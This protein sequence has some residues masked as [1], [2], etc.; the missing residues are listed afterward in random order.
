M[1]FNAYFSSLFIRN[2]A[3]LSVFLAKCFELF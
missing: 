2:K 1:D 3:L